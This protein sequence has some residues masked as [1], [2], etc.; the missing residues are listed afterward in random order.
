V[1]S[2]GKEKYAMESNLREAMARICQ[3][4]G[5]PG[6]DSFTQ[7]WAFE[8]PEGFRTREF[9]ER[10]LTAY[11]TPGY[12]PA[13]KHVLMHLIL[14]VAND[15]IERHEGLE[16]GAWGR[17]VALLQADHRL[18][19]ELIEHWALVGEPLESGF[20]LT[21]RMRAVREKTIEQ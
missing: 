12:G 7:D 8:L 9:F 14:D 10:Y 4:L 19:R 1:G 15:L 11:S 20:R 5:L 2:G 17:V 18:H 13:E 21:P 3:D 16:W 6:G